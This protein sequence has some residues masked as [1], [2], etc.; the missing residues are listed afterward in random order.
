MS[1]HTNV[2]SGIFV[3]ELALSL[4][5]LQ[6]PNWKASLGRPIYTQESTTVM[7]HFISYLLLLRLSSCVNKRLEMTFDIRP[8]SH[9]RFGNF[10]ITN[11]LFPLS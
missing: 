5:L 9:A 8:T 3:V 10:V 11:N 6:E 4:H 2:Y 1:L 7:S